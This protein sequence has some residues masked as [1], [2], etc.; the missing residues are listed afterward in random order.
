MSP[1]S[2][3]SIGL[4]PEQ[5]AVLGADGVRKYELNKLM[6]NP[7]EAERAQADLERVRAETARLQRP[8]KTSDP[9]SDTVAR[10]RAQFDARMEQGRK[11]GLA[12]EDLMQYASTGKMQTANEKQT[13][14]QAN[15]ALFSR[16]ME[17]SNQII[18]DP[19]IAQY[20]MGVKGTMNRANAAIPV[21]GNAFVDPQYQQLDQAK[22]DFINAALR[23]ESGANIN[24]GEFDSADKQ[25]FPQVGDSPEVLKQ[26]AQNRATAIQGIY[27]AAAPQYRRSHQVETGAPVDTPAQTE[28]R[29]LRRIR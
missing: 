13:Q 10:E 8:E 28:P 22:R 17:Q 9:Y 18:S 23:R 1:E 19:A 2:L 27:D 29:V 11:L 25:Y 14:D 7:M 16:R 12:G 24:A 26:K 6:Q 3:R 20:G 21:I 15:A 4:T 5:G